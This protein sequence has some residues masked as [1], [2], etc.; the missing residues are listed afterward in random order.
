M[1][2]Y[3]A[4]RKSATPAST[5]SALGDGGGGMPVCAAA[6]VHA[7]RSAV[8]RGTA[9][10]ACGSAATSLGPGSDRRLCCG[11]WR[12]DKPA[13]DSCAAPFV[14]GAGCTTHLQPRLARLQPSCKA[15]FQ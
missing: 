10:N 14:P 9:A 4:A 7:P 3:P 11:V 1:T 13:A 2:W 6:L 8:E 12:I 15:L 5:A